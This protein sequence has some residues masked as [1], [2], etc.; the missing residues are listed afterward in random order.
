MNFYL[1]KIAVSGKFD[2]DLVSFVNKVDLGKID[3]ENFGI[4]FHPVIRE[5]CFREFIGNILSINSKYNPKSRYCGIITWNAANLFLAKIRELRNSGYI[6][7]IIILDWTQLVLIIDD[8]K[9]IY[10]EAIYISSEQDVTYLGKRRE[11]EKERLSVRLFIKKE[12]AK[13]CKKFEL[14]A[15]SKSDLVITYNEKD[16]NLLIADGI[17]QKSVKM[18]APYFHKTAAKRAVSNN[19][20]IFFGYMRRF[21]NV[22]AVTWFIDNVMPKINDLPCRFVV[23]GGGLD[24]DLKA[25]ENQKIV[26]TGFVPEIDSYFSKAMCFA[27]PL[28]YGAGIKIKVIEAL[29][30]GIP[31][32]TNKIGI[33]GIPAVKGKDYI[34]CE[35]AADYSEAIRKIYLKTEKVVDGSESIKRNFDYVKSAEEYISLIEKIGNE[36]RCC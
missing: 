32:L 31:V 8:V 9:K 15:L 4:K 21:E 22:N 12:I 25:L 18:L 5:K 29:Y 26:F 10:P 11:A 30:S 24:D 36:K 16:R 23:V 33:E 19:D 1:K 35:N 2:V 28:N 34:H 17:N 27:A 14:Q 20:I 7:D 3:V 13:T 6:P